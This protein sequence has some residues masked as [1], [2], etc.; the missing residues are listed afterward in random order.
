MKKFGVLVALVVGC[1][2]FVTAAQADHAGAVGVWFTVDGKSKVEIY[3]CEEKLCGKIIWLKEPKTEEG[4]DKVD[5]N[6]PD[7][8]LQTRKILG[9][10]LLKEF[11]RDGDEPHA[12][13]DGKIYNPEDGQLYS[14]NMELLD[15]GTLKVRGYVGLPM[16]GKTQIWTREG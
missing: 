7:E 13:T 1:L 4:K 5:V 14:C 2:S 9:L 10:N 12:W 16:F 11:V 15:D 6:N 8:N 3:K